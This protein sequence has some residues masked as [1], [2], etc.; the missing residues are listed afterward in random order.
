MNRKPIILYR[1]SDFEKEELPFASKFFNCTNR[2]P[3]IQ[4]DDLVIGRYSLWP[5]YSDQVK[6][7]EY[8]GA[9]LINSYQQHLYI[10]DLGNY[11]QDLQELTPYTWTSL[12]L[13]PDNGSFVLKGETN[14]RK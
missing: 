8:V 2:R 9:K 7:I 4:K 13:L 14:S 6:D 3:D 5:F 1:G 11:I 12:E 10:A